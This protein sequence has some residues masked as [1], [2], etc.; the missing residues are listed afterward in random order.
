MTPGVLIIIII[1]IVVVQDYPN[2]CSYGKNIIRSS[3]GNS[4]NLLNYIAL[5]AGIVIQILLHVQEFQ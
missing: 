5:G 3:D 2:P 1:I 4:G